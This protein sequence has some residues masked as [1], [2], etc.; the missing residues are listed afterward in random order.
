MPQRP[1]PG[2]AATRAPARTPSP[3]ACCRGNETWAILYACGK[4]EE[5]SDGGLKWLCDL[6]AGGISLLSSE[7]Q[8]TW[9]EEGLEVGSDGT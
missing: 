4:E 9:A 7:P 6:G 1:Q 3:S 5:A 2:D 8:S